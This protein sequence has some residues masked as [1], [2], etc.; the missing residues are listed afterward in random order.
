MPRTKLRRLTLEILQEN[1]LPKKKILEEVRKESGKAVSDKTINEILMNLLKD[2]EIYISG[3]DFQVYNGMKR[4]QSIKA[5][6][7]IFG[8]MKVNPLEIALLINHLD[9]ND[10]EIAKESSY[11]L[12][13][14]FRRKLDGPDMN[15][16]KINNIDSLFNKIMY[17]INT[18]TNDQKTVLTN[19]LAW[20][21]SE[22]DESSNLLKS[23]IEYVNS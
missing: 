8:Y 3:Y 2:G 21:L 18:Q 1:D 19:K 10:P 20:S 6:G 12:K 22:E 16:I 13:I 23:I 14:I 7:I 11:K 17:Y 9:S 4:I 5:D 15:E